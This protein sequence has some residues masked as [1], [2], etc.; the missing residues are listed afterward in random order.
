MPGH[1]GEH[2]FFVKWLAD[3]LEIKVGEPV[4]KVKQVVTD[5][6]GEPLL[7]AEEYLRSDCFK[8]LINRRRS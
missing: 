5:I 7:Y 3:M 6:H 4:L 1:H 2:L 8:L